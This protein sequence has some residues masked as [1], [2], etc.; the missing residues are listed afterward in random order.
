MLDN[1]KLK[2]L[3][4]VLLLEREPV[5]IS[6]LPKD[7]ELHFDVKKHI[8]AQCFRWQPKDIVWKSK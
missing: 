7:E 4:A 2:L 8:F 1:Q 3:K 6:S 5:G